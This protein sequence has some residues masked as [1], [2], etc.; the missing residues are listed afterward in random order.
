VAAGNKIASNKEE[1]EAMK[2]EEP[3]SKALLVQKD[4]TGDEEDMSEEAG[5]HADEYDRYDNADLLDSGDGD[6]P[7]EEDQINVESAA[8]DTDNSTTDA[9]EVQE[10]N[11]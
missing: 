5:D 1:K 11:E 4:D 9:E 8:V 6:D 7:E 3:N 10:I 2:R